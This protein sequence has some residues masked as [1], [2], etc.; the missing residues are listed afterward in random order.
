MKTISTTDIWT[1]QHANHYDCFNG[2]FVDGIE[3]NVLPYDRYKVVKNC[4]CII[5]TSSG[6]GLVV[7]NKHNAIIFYNKGE[8]VR[9]ALLD[10]KTD[11][12]KCIKKALAQP[13]GHI[14][15]DELLKFRKVQRKIIDL[16]EKPIYNKHNGKD[17]MDIGSCDRLSLLKCMLGGSYTE[18]ETV[19]GNFTNNDLDFNPDIKIYYKLVTDE[20]NFEISHRGAFLNNDR[21]I[22]LQENSSLSLEDVYKLFSDEDENV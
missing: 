16:K 14:T 1:E 6:G 2:A 12:D 4:N 3:G 7:G 22:I 10:E 5:S 20:E 21:A 13:I 8:V 19:L 11:V 15:I 9:L 18:S 17:E